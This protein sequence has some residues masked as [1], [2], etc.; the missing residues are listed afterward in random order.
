GRVRVHNM[1]CCPASLSN[2]Y[3]VTLRGKCRFPCR[4]ILFFRQTSVC[5]VAGLLEYAQNK[6]QDYDWNWNT[7]QPKKNA[8]HIVSFHLYLNSI[9]F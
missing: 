6:Q 9:S 3:G 7:N 2:V 1:A 5:G 4:A 8:A